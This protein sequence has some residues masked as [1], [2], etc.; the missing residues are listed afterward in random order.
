LTS[1][2]GIRTG[3]ANVEPHEGQSLKSSAY[4]PIS[5]TPFECSRSHARRVKVA[6][7]P[8]RFAMLMALYSWLPKQWSP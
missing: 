4:L 7:H 2:L 1:F 8:Q 3:I 6:P 5:F